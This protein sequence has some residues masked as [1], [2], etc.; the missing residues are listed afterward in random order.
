MLKLTGVCLSFLLLFA[1]QPGPG[2][3]DHSLTSEKTPWTHTRFDNQ[4]E[5]FTFAIF[6]DLTGGEREGIFSVAVE[7]LNLL[8]P[9]LIV[10]VGDLVEG[11]SEDPSEW[12]RQ[13]DSF[14][15]RADGARAPVF[16]AGGNH[17]L[18]GELARKVWE[19]RLGP[20]YY[21]FLYKEVL[22]LVMDTEDNS[23]ERMAE[24][25]AMRDEA[26]E[27][28]QTEGREAFLETAYYALP[29]RTAGTIGKAQAEFFVDVIEDHPDVRWTFVL[30]HKPAWEKENETHFAAIESALSDQAYTV[31]YGHTHLYKYQQR[32]GRDYIN[33]STTGGVQFPDRGRSVDH[34]MLVTVDENGIS[35]ANLLMEG[36]RDK[37]MH[38]PLGG[39]SLV[40]EQE[41][42]EQ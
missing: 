10:N 38:L 17:D 1:C 16:Y 24:I 7:Q 22:F 36:I 35:M 39:D 40:F 12:H 15:A 11:G 18:T 6:S 8:R 13:W 34:L 9:E 27:T 33:L 21:H 41:L 14:D 5:K 25:T 2:T 37:T 42:K 29:E 20:R 32:K 19:E 23:P 30:V 31:F 26:V 3:F 4:E 28:L